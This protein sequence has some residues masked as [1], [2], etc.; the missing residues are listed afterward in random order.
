MCLAPTLKPTPVVEWLLTKTEK[1]VLASI[2]TT[3]TEKCSGPIKKTISRITP[4]LL[5]NLLD[6]EKFDS[7]ES[8]DLK[9]VYIII[10][11]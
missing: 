3:L 7:K 6:D 5:E 2:R 8:I 11:K 9:Q 10:K 4:Q 1:N